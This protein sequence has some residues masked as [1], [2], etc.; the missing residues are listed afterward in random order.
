MERGGRREGEGR[1]KKGRKGT[2]RG[3][4]GKKQKGSKMEEG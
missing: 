2:I 3:G 1:L 4:E